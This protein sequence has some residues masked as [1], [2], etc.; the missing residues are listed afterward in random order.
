LPNSL[1]GEL[2]LRP[3]IIAVAVA[4][5]FMALCDRA[6]AGFVVDISQVGSNVVVNGSGSID[7]SLLTGVGNGGSRALVSGAFG[8]VVLGPVSSS[9]GIFGGFTGP[10]SFGTSDNQ[11]ASSTSG[12]SFGLIASV[13]GFNEPVLSLPGT[14]VSGA[15]LTATATFDNTTILL[16]GLTPG[17]YNYTTTTPTGLV[18][19]VFTVNITSVPEP[20]SITMAATAMG[21]VGGLALRRRR[22]KKA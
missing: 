1:L 5:G 21:L 18:E 10:L 15:Q 8:S 7:L 20:S 13:N 4:T 9:Q 11:F 19:T 2:T 12:D 14:Y 3:I 17:T 22:G 6:E 16:L